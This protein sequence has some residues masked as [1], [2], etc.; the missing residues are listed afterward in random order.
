MSIQWKKGVVAGVVGTTIMT[1]VGLWIAPLMGIPAMNPAQMLAGAMGGVLALGWGAHF[2]IGTVL[3]LT[4]AA[5]AGKLPGPPLARGA[6][7]GIAPWLF[8]QIVV[9]PMMGMPL[10][11]GAVVVAM[12]SL[13]GHMV[14]GAVVGRIYGAP[15]DLARA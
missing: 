6:L 8:A 15:P 2:L 4:Y 11:S 13:L 5:V 7:Y 9:L 12:G 3:A 14:Y 1:V 10:F